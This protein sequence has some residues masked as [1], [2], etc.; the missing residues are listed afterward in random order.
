MN[1]ID[2]SVRADRF[3]TP[4]QPPKTIGSDGAGVVTETGSEVTTVA[5]GDEV[6]FTGL[7]IGSEGSYAEYAVIAEAQAVAKP[8]AL[9]FEQ[10]AAMGLV[11][12]TAHYALVRRAARAAGRDRPRPG[13]RRRRRQRRRADRPRPRRTRA[14]DGLTRG[15]RAGRW[16]SWAPNG[17][18]S[19]NAV[20]VAA[21]VRRLTEDRGA[22]VVIDPPRRTTWRSTSR[23]WRRAAASSS[24]AAAPAAQ[25]SLPIGPAGGIDAGL[26]FMSSSNAG[27]AG[28]ARTLAEL[29]AMAAAGSLRA[30]IG[31]VLPL[32]EARR[33][34]ELLEQ[35]HFGKIVLRAVDGLT[36]SRQG[37]VTAAPSAAVTCPCRYPVSPLTS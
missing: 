34:H 21:E 22:D 15:R 29:A 24:S 1:P 23:P 10:A 25:A 32:A 5:V 4:K 36:C 6:M 14:G 19:G 13:R 37:H 28:T 9:S 3:P 17:R 33:A 11:F 30:V 31:A 18:S 2:V 12:P 20:D 8:A 27:R 35:H 16:R 7:G 26:L